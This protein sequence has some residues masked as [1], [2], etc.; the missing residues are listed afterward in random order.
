MS[1]RTILH[2]SEFR[3]FYTKSGEA[4]AGCCK[5]LGAGQTLEEM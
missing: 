4:F 2:M 1:E 3:L 5:L